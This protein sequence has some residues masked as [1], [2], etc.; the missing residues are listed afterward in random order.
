MV[1]V[2]PMLMMLAYSMILK[3][4]AFPYNSSINQS[5]EEDKQ[6]GRMVLMKVRR[7]QSIMLRVLMV[8]LANCTTTN[9]AC[10]ISNSPDGNDSDDDDDDYSD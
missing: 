7:I 5:D 2:V 3:M 10:T 4:W 9:I 6:E 8:M 1:L